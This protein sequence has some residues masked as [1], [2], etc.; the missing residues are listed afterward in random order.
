[1]TQIAWPTE[2]NVAGHPAIYAESGPKEGDE[3][4][5]EFEEEEWDE[6]DDELDDDEFDDDDEEIDDWGDE[7]EESGE[8]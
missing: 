3:I 5:G 6:L 2:P 8:E 7:E 4:E 1:M